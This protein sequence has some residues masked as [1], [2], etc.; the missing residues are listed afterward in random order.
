[1]RRPVCIDVYTVTAYIMCTLNDV[2][3]YT[4]LGSLVFPISARL[5]CGEAK[6]ITPFCVYEYY[7]L[8]YLK[9]NK[10]VLGMYIHTVLR[11]TLVCGFG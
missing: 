1:M 2:I 7:G 6:N 4:W 3:D 10:R 9:R 8:R 11:R 5:Y